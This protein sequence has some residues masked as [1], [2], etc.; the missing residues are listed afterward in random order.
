MGED[1]KAGKIIK[2]ENLRRKKEGR[3]QTDRQTDRQEDMTDRH[4]NKQT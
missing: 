3:G 2:S 1:Q 4:K